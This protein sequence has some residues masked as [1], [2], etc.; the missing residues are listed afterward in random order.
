MGPGREGVF[1]PAQLP[2][3]SG[4]IPGKILTGAVWAIIICAGIFV[5]DSDEICDSLRRD[6]I[7]E[8]TG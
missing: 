5:G 8:D 6:V 7:R 4:A 2:P 1:D 3:L